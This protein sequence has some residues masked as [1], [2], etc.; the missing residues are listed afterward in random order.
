VQQLV[1][2]LRRQRGTGIVPR[3]GKAGASKVF[4]LF[5]DNFIN[6]KFVSLQKFV[7]QD[8][9]GT[10]DCLSWGKTSVLPQLCPEAKEYKR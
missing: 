4:Y 8:N 1:W 6:R 10:K 5:F 7:G 3:Q 9:W 2:K